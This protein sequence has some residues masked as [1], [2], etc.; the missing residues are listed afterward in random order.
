MKRLLLLLLFVLCFAPNA[1]AYTFIDT[2]LDLNAVPSF[3]GND[4]GVTESFSQMSY[5]AVTV[6]KINLGT[7][8][9]VDSGLAYITSLTTTAGTQPVDDEG[10]GTYG[11]YGIALVWDDLTGQVTSNDGST[12][13]AD[14]TSGTIRVYVDH[15]P[16]AL[17]VNTPSTYSDGTLVAEI[18][19]TSGGYTLNMDGTPGSSYTLWGSFE[20]LLEDFWFE[21]S[22]D[23][24]MNEYLDLDWLLAYSAGDNDSNSVELDYS[25]PGFLTV[26]SDHNSSIDVALVPEPGSFLLLGAGLIGVGFYARRRK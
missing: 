16:Y 26:T 9:I 8:Q 11:G 14:Y 12:I 21:T 13:T 20:S 2:Y 1:F 15:N 6:S 17:D 7:G 24:D 3:S 5:D 22:T 10:L 25:D 23:L 19:V 4:D 18:E